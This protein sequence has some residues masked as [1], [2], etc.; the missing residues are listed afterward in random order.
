MVIEF[1][2]GMVQLT[3]GVVYFGRAGDL[4]FVI[5]VSFLY[6]CCPIRIRNCV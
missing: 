5:H 3:V 2:G 1:V 6:D 4:E